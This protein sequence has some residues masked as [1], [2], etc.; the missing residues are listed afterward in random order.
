MK[1]ILAFFLCLY[2]LS[3]AA[4]QA[5]EIAYTVRSTELKTKPFADAATLLSLAEHSKVE[6][7]T[8]QASWMQVK[9][10]GT[11]GWVK[12]LS[13]RLEGGKTQ[14]GD[15]GLGALFNVA[16]TGSSGSTVTTGVRGLS[17]EN[18]KKARPNPRA[19]ETMQNFAASERSATGFAKAGKLESQQMDYLPPPT[20][21]EN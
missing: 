19:L 11:I 4:A 7:V 13:L 9:A 12:M 16:A 5:G 17:E 18:L 2:T 8:R 10:D 1:P 15:A 3:H 21:G 20:K 14:T 6:I